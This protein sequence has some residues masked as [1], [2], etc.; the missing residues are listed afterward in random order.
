MKVVYTRE[1]LTR[2]YKDLP[3]EEIEFYC[4]KGYAREVI[5]YSDNV[6][7]VEGSKVKYLKARHGSKQALSRWENL[8]FDKQ[9]YRTIEWLG[10]CGRNVTERHPSKLDNWEILEVFKRREL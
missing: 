7:F 1:D 3:I 4:F 2:E 8:P 6:V 5:S 9:F 10:S